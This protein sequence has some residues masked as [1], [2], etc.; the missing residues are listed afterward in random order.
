MWGACVRERER[1]RERA[2]RKTPTE[3]GGGRRAF[4]GLCNW[5]PPL[6]ESSHETALTFQAG[7]ALSGTRLVWV[8]AGCVGL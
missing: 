2:E 4:F 1:E 6:L 7:S 3:R 5:V 8:G